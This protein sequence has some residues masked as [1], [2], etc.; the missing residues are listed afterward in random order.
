MS[1]ESGDLSIGAGVRPRLAAKA[2]VQTDRVSGEPVLLYPEGALLLNPTGAAVGG[3]CDGRRTF[4]ELVN[5]LAARYNSPSGELSGDVGEYL[6]RLRDHG[7][8][9]LQPPGGGPS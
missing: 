8:L 9:E 5:E 1:D 7:L 3:L 4:A 2:R 6:I